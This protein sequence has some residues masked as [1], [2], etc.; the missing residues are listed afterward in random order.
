MDA[1][2]ITNMN[3][4]SAGNWNCSF[5]YTGGSGLSFTGKL[6][7]TDAEF[8]AYSGVASIADAIG[9]ALG[10]LSANT[11]TVTKAESKTTT[12]ANNN[13]ANVW[14]VSFNSAYAADDG[15]GLSL[16]GW[17]NI[18]DSVYQSQTV[19][20]QVDNILSALNALG[21]V[22][23]EGAN[24]AAAQVEAA[25][26][27]NQAVEQPVSDQTSQASAASDNTDTTEAN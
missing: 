22:S 7:A 14:V 10:S 16:S 25:A 8:R 17:Y 12:D 19:S 27:N 13:P 21:P 2:N 1:V 3:Q 6:T 4:T 20:Q 11:L 26:N 18:A 5:S 23:D 24:Q 9:V 15:T